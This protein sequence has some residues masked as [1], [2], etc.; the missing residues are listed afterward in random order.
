MNAG[1][2]VLFA[3]VLKEPAPL[4]GKQKTR[5]GGTGRAGKKFLERD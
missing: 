5:R 2:G 3:S 1:N 4:A